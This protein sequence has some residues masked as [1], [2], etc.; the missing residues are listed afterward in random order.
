MDL[1]PGVC[2]GSADQFV[3]NLTLNLPME[4]L[5]ESCAI[6][7]LFSCFWSHSESCEDMVSEEELVEKRSWPR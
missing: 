3:L 7:H 2:H 4:S 6:M 5:S 1:K